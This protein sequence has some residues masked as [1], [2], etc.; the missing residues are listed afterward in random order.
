MSRPHSLRS[1]LRLY[2]RFA[3]NADGTS[4]LPATS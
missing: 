2:A 4:E 1:K 3:L